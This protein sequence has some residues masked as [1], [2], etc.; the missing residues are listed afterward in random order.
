MGGCPS[1]IYDHQ[2]RQPRRRKPN[3]AKTAA[4]RILSVDATRVPTV[5]RLLR[6]CF[7][8]R[9]I[10]ADLHMMICNVFFY[11]IDWF[12][13]WVLMYRSFSYDS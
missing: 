10:F 2:V 1:E 13:I 12:Y 8:D 11:F 7:A 6:I 4:I 9:T 3:P 5:G